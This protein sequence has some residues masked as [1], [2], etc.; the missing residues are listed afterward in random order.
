MDEKNLKSIESV[1]EKN[2]HNTSDVDVLAKRLKKIGGLSDE[3]AQY[4][5][6]YWKM[7]A[8]VIVIVVLFFII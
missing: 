8:G 5:A 3:F 2:L 1:I 4:I 7:V 6:M